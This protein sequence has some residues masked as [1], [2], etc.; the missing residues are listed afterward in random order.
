MRKNRLAGGIMTEIAVLAILALAFVGGY[1]LS[2]RE[3]DAVSQTW[4]VIGAELLKSEPAEEGA[5]VPGEETGTPAEE[6]RK[7]A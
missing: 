1:I 6:K 2:P 5:A 3:R 4:P 7:A